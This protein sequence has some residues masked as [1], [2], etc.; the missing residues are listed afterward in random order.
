MKKSPTKKRNNAAPNRKNSAAANQKSDA[1]GVTW[2]ESPLMK[3]RGDLRPLLLSFLLPFAAACVIL[4]FTGLSPFGDKT[5]LAWDG[6]KQYYPFF[7]GFREKLLSG[8]SLQY[9]WDVGMGTGYSSLFAYYLASPLNWLCVLVPSSLLPH[10]FA[11]LSVVKIACAGLFFALFLRV[12]YRRN[13]WS[14]ALFGLTYAF[15]AWVCGYYWNNIWLDTFALLPLLI[16]GTVSLLRD[17]R[18]RLYIIALAL[19]LWC[20]YYLSYFS[21]IFVLLSF[22][23]YCIVCWKGFKN[24]LRRFLRIGV[25]TL[26]GFGLAAVLLIPTLKAMMNT[27]STVGTEFEPWAMNFA[28]GVSGTVPEGQSLLGFLFKVTLPGL[29]SASKQILTN[30]M[31]APSVNDIYPAG[32]PN[33]YCGFSTVVLAIYFCCCGKIRLREKLCNVFLLI[34]LLLGFVFRKL[35]YLW[36]GFH[37]PNGLPYRFSHLFSFVTI[38][39][40]YRAFTLMDSF[41]RWYLAI[42]VPVAGLLIWNA[43][44]AESLT[45]ASVIAAIAVLGAMV[46]AFL[47][48]RKSRTCRAAAAWIVTVVIAAEMISCFAIGMNKAPLQQLSVYPQDNEAIQ[49][50]LDRAEKARKTDDDDGFAR[51]EV[52]LT[53]LNDARNNGALYGYRGVS[54]FASSANV[55]FCRFS[56]ALGISA[57]PSMNWY[58]YNESTPVSNTLCSVKYL[59]DREGEYRDPRSNTLI[60]TEGNTNLLRNEYYIS[61]GFMADAD[62]SDF[63]VEAES[64]N[65][66][67]DQNGLFKLATGV[68]EDVYDPMPCENMIAWTQGSTIEPYF[69]TTDRYFRYSSGAEKST[70]S[71]YFRADRDGLYCASTRFQNNTVYVYLN[72][73]F[74]FDRYATSRGMFSL[75]RLS[76]GDEIQLVYF[77]EPGRSGWFVADVARMDD[78]AFQRGY[79]MLADEPWKLTEVSD[80]E[81]SGTVSALRDGLFYTSIPYEPGW[82]AEVDGKAVELAPT[83]DPSAETLKLTDAVIAFPLSEGAHEITLRYRTPGLTAGILISAASLLIFC[84]LILLRRKDNAIFPDPPNSQKAGIRKRIK[85]R[86]SRFGKHEEVES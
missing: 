78:E 51:T 67:S 12:V 45:T 65:P 7:K 81:L 30:L 57:L 20:N 83:F 75:G 64:D 79:D 41:K 55:N 69:N 42:I 58:V 85:N 63:S 82:T 80:T 26:L 48:F 40:A 27:Y 54:T 37:F 15:C 34:F 17:G 23:V 22:I 73:Q 43:W 9:T 13:D 32:L 4:A 3:Q 77:V 11:L 52:T 21:C 31:P 10:F 61:A 38:C 47:L 68:H 50:L 19:S 44:G 16:A 49:S 59:L 36:H 76:A 39:M 60:K 56:P 29:W 74:A 46:T 6:W 53:Q 25:C 62:L 1:Q 35:D 24:F 28:P 71:V 8:G 72:G 86:L 5:L 84:A 70:F 66:I 18:F 14:I 33:I 2:E